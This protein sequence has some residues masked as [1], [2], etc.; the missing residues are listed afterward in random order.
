MLKVKYM[1]HRTNRDIRTCCKIPCMFAY[2]RYHRLRW[3]GCLCRM[4]NTRYP[5]QIAF[6]ACSPKCD[7][8]VQRRW[9]V[10]IEADLVVLNSQTSVVDFEN[11]W[12]VLSNDAVKWKT[13]I[14]EQLYH[15]DSFVTP[16]EI[17]RNTLVSGDNRP[18]P[19]LLCPKSFYHERDLNIHNAKVHDVRESR[20]RRRDLTNKFSVQFVSSCVCPICSKTCK[21]LAGCRTH[22]SRMHFDDV[23]C[24]VCNNMFAS[25]ND[26]DEQVCSL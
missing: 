24:L 6:G 7:G 19:C 21:S 11:S 18:F 20:W 17:R 9:D 13:I 26:R 23:V 4:E 15:S 12:F 14:H 1:E 22:W 2:I 5:K 25:I 16:P 10:T 8:R 3:L